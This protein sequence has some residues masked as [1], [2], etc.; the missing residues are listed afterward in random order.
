MGTQNGQALARRSDVSPERLSC[1]LT[2][3]WPLVLFGSRTPGLIPRAQSSH[4]GCGTRPYPPHPVTSRSVS[5]SSVRGGP[6]RMSLEGKARRCGREGATPPGCPLRHDV[7]WSIFSGGVTDPTNS[8]YETGSILEL[9]AAESIGLITEAYKKPGGRL[10]PCYILPATPP[11]AQSAQPRTAPPRTARGNAAAR[12]EPKPSPSLRSP[13]MGPR[14]AAPGAALALLGIAAAAAARS[15]ALPDAGPHVN[16][17]WGEPIRLRH[18]YTASKHGLFSC[19]LRIG[20]DGRVDAVG[21]QSPQS[22]R[23]D[24]RERTGRAREWNGRAGGRRRGADGWFPLPA[25][26]LE[27]RAV[28]VRTVAIKGVRSSRYLCMD[29]AGR[30]HGQVSPRSRIA[31][32]GGRR[33]GGWS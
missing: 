6:A 26:L 1:S 32:G 21:S 28:A 24:L 9:D 2:S 14:P 22:K 4:R 10:G 5:C 23:R 16:Y 25:G 20:G 27:I 11:A 18:L 12:A 31:A 30:L 29:E 15:L 8:R 7:I 17:G 13:R 19:F 33:R 3:A